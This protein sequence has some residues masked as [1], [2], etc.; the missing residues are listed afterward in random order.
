MS[1]LLDILWVLP[2]DYLCGKATQQVKTLEIPC[3]WFLSVQYKISEL[4][5]LQRISCGAVFLLIL[6]TVWQWVHYEASDE[7]LECYNETSPTHPFPKFLN[8]TPWRSDRVDALWNVSLHFWFH[9]LFVQ[10]LD[11]WLA[12][13]NQWLQEPSLAVQT[14]RWI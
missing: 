3:E 11:L 6:I 14:H 5:W 10:E 7:S 1:Y 2:G 8:W 13:Y 4:L 12:V 9:I